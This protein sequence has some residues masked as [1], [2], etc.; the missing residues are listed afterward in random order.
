MWEDH[1]RGLL[2]RLATSVLQPSDVTKP[3]KPV[4][5]FE[6]IREQKLKSAEEFLKA[7]NSK[8]IVIGDCRRGDLR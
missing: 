5:N 2:W 8:E 6:T 3:L 4:V 1:T 7:W